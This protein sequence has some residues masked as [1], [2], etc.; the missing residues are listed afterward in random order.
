MQD[1]KQNNTL[2][3]LIGFMGSGKSTLGRHLAKALGWNFIDLDD[4]F[5]NKFRTTVPLYF[6]EFGERGFRD[7]ERAALLDMENEN[8]AVIAAG[9]GTPCFFDNMDFMNQTGITVYMK[10]TPEELAK[11]LSEAKT[12]RPLVQGKTGEE[13][14]AY[15]RGKLAEREPFYGKAQIIADAS[16]LDLNGY[17][18]ILEEAGITG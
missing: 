13:L 5:E 6:K 2:I 1:T 10:V 9:G 17:L 3:Y 11:R 18:R 15:I 4:H 16:K 12:V 14:I 7:A 8:R